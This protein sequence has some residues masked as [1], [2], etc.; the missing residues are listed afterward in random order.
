MKKLIGILGVAA[1]MWAAPTT[2]AA[3]EFVPESGV[4]Y[5][6]Q[7]E[8]T[9]LLLGSGAE[10]FARLLAPAK[11]GAAAYELTF[12]AK[13]EGQYNI[14]DANG[15]Y[16][17]KDGYNTMFGAYDESKAEAFIFGLAEVAETEYY[18]VTVGTAAETCL[19][20]DNVGAG[21]KVYSDKGLGYAT[22]KYSIIKAT[23]VLYEAKIEFSSSLVQIMKDNELENSG[24]VSLT[25]TN[26][27]GTVTFT[28]SEGIMVEPA[29]LEMTDGVKAEI[30]ISTAGAV[31]TEGTVTASYDGK[32]LATVNVEVIEAAPYYY[33]MNEEAG[34]VIGGETAKAVLCENTRSDDMLFRMVPVP[35]K[36][37]FYYFVQKS[38]GLYFRNVDSGSGV[39]AHYCEFG[40]SPERAEW[41]MTEKDG[42][43]IMKNS[44]QDRILVPTSMSNPMGAQLMCYG[45]SSDAGCVWQFLN[46]NDMPEE[47]PMVEIRNT[48]VLVEQDGLAFTTEVRAMY[49]DGGYVTVVPSKDVTVFPTT[50]E[51]SFKRTPLTITTTAPE[52]T[53][54]S[55]KFYF[56]ETLLE[57]LEFT[58]SPRFNRYVI[59]YN[60]AAGEGN[61]ALGTTEGNRAMFVEYD[62]SNPLEQFIA[63]PASE[64]D[65]DTFYLI[66][67]STFGYL[68]ADGGWDCIVSSDKS[69]VWTLDGFSEDLSAVAIRSS[70]GTLAADNFGLGDKVYTNKGPGTTWTFEAVGQINLSSYEV[71]LAD[72][73][74]TA[75]VNVTAAGLPEDLTITCTGAAKADKT[76]LPAEGG[77]LVVS[78][79]ANSTETSGTIVLTSGRFT[80]T[81]IVRMVSTTMT[82]NVESIDLV[83]KGSTG[84]FTVSATDIS[85][86]V[87]ITASEG[88]A[89][90]PATIEPDMNVEQIVTVSYTGK[91]AATGTI[92]VEC[93]TIKREIAVSV[94]FNPDITVELPEEGFEF[95]DG[96]A[97]MVVTPVDLFEP[98]LVTA[99][100]DL[101]IEPASIEPDRKDEYVFLSVNDKTQPGEITITLASGDVTKTLKITYEVAGLDVAVAMPLALVADNGTL[102]VLG[103]ENARMVVATAA[104]AVVADTTAKTVNLS[105]GLYIVRV[106]A[107]GATLSTKV[108]VK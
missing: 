39:M 89:V 77:E 14:T 58:V 73:T 93:G 59:R 76:T 23:E 102:R 105:T 16:M 45:L 63:M 94:S 65:D 26:F 78:L 83:G 1:A 87:T 19:A 42:G 24:K 8:G 56:G 100:T 75:T 50:I 44:K 81:L 47:E 80:R 31:G 55:V 3:E 98:V 10:N 88:F 107:D 72:R 7:H 37:N 43:Y 106:I 92:T 104:G 21:Q 51:D 22:G 62:M 71:V 11:S 5:C 4:K 60:D 29:T 35:G 108:L 41:T 70:K 38:S 74:A 17:Y 90:S 48:D 97:Y 101:D 27:S 85:E 57:T 86:P 13:G 30:T 32:D 67:E 66:Q 52:G 49:L 18:R 6:L 25:G 82:V 68:Y 64:D 9:D 61:L 99:S 15:Q 69:T 103:A 46:S 33:I 91:V 40:E 95:E 20:P 54:C 36:A 2:A 84:R 96:I 12:I 28:A 34:L 53:Q 79:D